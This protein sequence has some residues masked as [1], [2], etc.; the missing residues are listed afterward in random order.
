[1]AYDLL[2][3]LWKKVLNS[4][5]VGPYTLKMIQDSLKSPSPNHPDSQPVTKSDVIYGY[6]FLLNRFPESEQVVTNKVNSGITFIE[7]RSALQNSVE[8]GSLFK[9]NTEHDAEYNIFNYTSAFRPFLWVLKYKQSEAND[10]VKQIYANISF[11]EPI[12]LCNFISKVISHDS[13]PPRI[14]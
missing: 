13:P 4:R 5:I 14:T 2:K 1:M 11:D 6:R 7:F 3:R 12:K 9:R 8:F 10:I